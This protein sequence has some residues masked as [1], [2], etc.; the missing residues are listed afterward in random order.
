[1]VWALDVTWGASWG[2][3]IWDTGRMGWGGLPQS[4]LPLSA[5]FFHI[6]HLLHLIMGVQSCVRHFLGTRDAGRAHRCW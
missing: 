3:S 6:G 4:S 1:M 2:I 5:M